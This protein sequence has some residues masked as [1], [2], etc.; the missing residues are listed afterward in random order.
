MIK[1]RQEEVV[2]APNLLPLRGN[3]SLYSVTITDSFNQQSLPGESK[4]KSPLF[5]KT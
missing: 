3:L 5:Y 1:K 2:Q 4:M